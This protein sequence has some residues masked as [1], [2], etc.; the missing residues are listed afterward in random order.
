[1]LAEALA[2]AALEEGEGAEGRGLAG[3]EANAGGPMPGAHPT[4]IQTGP[5]LGENEGS[6][7][8]ASVWLRTDLKLLIKSAPVVGSL[9]PVKAIS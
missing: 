7:A 6:K 8:A 5:H 1:M 9:A 2:E 4:I 3:E